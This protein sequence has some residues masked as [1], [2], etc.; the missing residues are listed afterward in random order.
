M[1]VL[2]RPLRA[3]VPARR[4]CLCRYLLAGLLLGWL[5]VSAAAAEGTAPPALEEIVRGMQGQWDKVQS[6]YVDFEING[7]PA[8]NPV[9]AKRYLLIDF[10]VT[11]K[12]S[13]AYK[14]NWRYYHSVGPA[15][16]ERIAPDVEPDW[17]VIPGG[18]QMKEAK[19]RKR[20]EA[21][22]LVGKEQ[23]ERA[24]KAVEEAKQATIPAKIM[25]A[26]DGK[27][28]RTSMG[29]DHVEVWTPENI[30]TDSG[31]IHQEYL[32]NIG[33]VLPDV[34]NTGDTRVKDRFPDAFLGVVG[35]QVK[36]ALEEVEDSRCV[37]VA[38]G[39][40]E[41]L[42]LDPAVNYG[43]RRHEL[44]D[45][46]SGLAKDIFR[47]RDFVEFA[48]GVW[49]PKGCVWERCAPAGAPANLRGK[50]LARYTFTVSKIGINSVPDDLF[51]LKIAPGTMV[52][53]TSVLPPKEGR[54]QSV[55]YP[56]PADTSQLDT[57]I[58]QALQQRQQ[59]ESKNFWQTVLIWGNA[60]LFL[61]IGA[62]VVYFRL[63]RRKAPS[64]EGKAGKL[65][66]AGA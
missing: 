51:T 48:P 8:G 31:W 44:Y 26:F 22:K 24:R 63:R 1:H 23:V 43:I 37:V 50:P 38:R 47:N 60:G 42:W 2:S 28:F 52:M 30:G 19:E 35:F 29:T 45:P 57:T 53:D 14:G 62:G 6:L 12:K 27:V 18:K 64:D 9:D 61:L 7:E 17:D 15:S 32:R 3:R 13:F 58:Q 4:G 49:L 65:R 25:A 33:R 20:A 46:E 10:F 11:Q 54:I 16:V 66:K 56:M 41:K 40:E 21:E 59:F 34:A 39:N 55:T 5:G 36:A